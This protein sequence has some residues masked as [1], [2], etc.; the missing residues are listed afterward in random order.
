MKP[1]YDAFD[2]LKDTRRKTF[3]II[4]LILAFVLAVSMTIFAFEG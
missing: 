2:T 3:L 4:A 1:N